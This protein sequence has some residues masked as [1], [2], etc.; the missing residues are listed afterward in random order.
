MCHIKSP[1]GVIFYKPINIVFAIGF[2]PG[3]PVEDP[4]RV[5]E[6]PE[7]IEDLV[8][9]KMSVIGHFSISDSDI[10]YLWDKKTI[11][12]RGKQSFNQG[13]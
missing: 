9:C 4:G 6:N 8:V 5:V 13:K 3:R 2:D 10:Q 11:G 12:N 7:A 1:F